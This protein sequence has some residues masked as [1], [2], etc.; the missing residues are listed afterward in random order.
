MRIKIKTDDLKRPINIRVPNSLVF[1]KL[2]SKMLEKVIRENSNG[3][4]DFNLDT[5]EIRKILKETKKKYNGN[6]KFVEIE[7]ANGEEILIEI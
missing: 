2:T 3:T 1:N 6:F 4:V 7:T 5:K